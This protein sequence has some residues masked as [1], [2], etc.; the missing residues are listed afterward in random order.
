CE[1]EWFHYGCVGLV[2]PP[3]GKWYCTSCLLSGHGR[4]KYMGGAAVS[5]LEHEEEVMTEEDAKKVKESR[6][7]RKETKREE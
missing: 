4:A 6:R 1:I 5:L 7:R 3:K 2:S